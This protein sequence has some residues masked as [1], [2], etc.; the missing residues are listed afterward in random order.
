MKANQEN[1][2]KMADEHYEDI[3]KSV[4]ALVVDTKVGA[5]RAWAM[6]GGIDLYRFWMLKH[7]VDRYTEEHEPVVRRAGRPRRKAL[8]R[9]AK[10]QELLGQLKSGRALDNPV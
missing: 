9:S 3:G 5:R 10:R 7:W 1:R 8:D 2:R 4:A 6:L